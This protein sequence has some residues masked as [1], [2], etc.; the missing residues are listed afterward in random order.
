M[1]VKGQPEIYS[2]QGDLTWFCDHLGDAHEA[3]EKMWEQICK[4][5]PELPKE[6]FK[7]NENL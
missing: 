3:M 1:P 5:H 2:D 6:G 7:D 4:D